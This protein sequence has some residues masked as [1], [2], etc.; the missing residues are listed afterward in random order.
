MLSG[1]LHRDSLPAES[2]WMSSLWKGS[3][4]PKKKRVTGGQISS[5]TK[6]EVSL[7]A[8]ELRLLSRDRGL[9]GSSHHLRFSYVSTV[10]GL[11]LKE[12]KCCVFEPQSGEK[13]M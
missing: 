13:T 8:E 2:P 5:W 3:R 12:G 7:D 11:H 4:R 9:L 6:T 10:A 1:M